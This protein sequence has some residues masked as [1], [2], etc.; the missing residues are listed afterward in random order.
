[1]HVSLNQVPVWEQKLTQERLFTIMLS[2]FRLSVDDCIQDY[3]KVLES[4]FS[5]PPRIHATSAP[6]GDDSEPGILAYDPQ[7]LEQALKNIIRD[8]SVPSQEDL[9]F[10]IEGESCKA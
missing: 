3:I 1:V 6:S 8:R 9:E 4:M 7:P 5:L 10:K 2:Q